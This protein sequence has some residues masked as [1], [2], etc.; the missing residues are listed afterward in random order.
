MQIQFSFSLPLLLILIIF[1]QPC[2]PKSFLDEKSGVLGFIHDAEEIV[3]MVQSDID[4][5][6][7]ERSEF[8][9]AKKR[10]NVIKVLEHFKN[11]SV[12]VDLIKLHYIKFSKK[13]PY[14][15]VIGYHQNRHHIDDMI[16]EMFEVSRRFKKMATMQIP[17]NITRVMSFFERI[18]RSEFDNPISN[19]FY[20]EL[21]DCWFPKKGFTG[22]LRQKYEMQ[23]RKLCSN[24][25]S[26]QQIVYSLY[27]DIALT[28]LKAYILLEY[29]LLIRRTVG[30]R[31]LM[32][33]TITVRFYYMNITENSLDTLT[34]TMQKADRGVW[35]CDSLSH[36]RKVTYEEVT[37]LIQ[38]YVENEVDLNNTESCS[39]ACPDYPNTTTMGYLDQKLC[40]QQ[41]KCLGPIHDCHS[42]GSNLTVCQ[43]PE[44]SNR[45]YEFIQY[46]DGS[47]VGPHKECELDFY[48][49]GSSSKIFSK[50]NYRFCL[51]DEQGPKS[52]R[53][54]NLRDIVSDLWANKVVTGV[55]FVKKH[56]IFHLQIQ[57]GQVLPRGSINES[58]VEWVPIDDYKITDPDIREGIDYHPLSH[59]ERGIDLDE[60]SSTSDE[61]SV[62]TGLRF[63]VSRGRLYLVVIFSPLD[64]ERG[65]LFQ[66]RFISTY[67]QPV[68]EARQKLDL[69]NLDIPT[70]SIYSS[71]PM[72][73]SNQYLEF[74]NTGM[75]KDAA[76]TTIPFIDIQDV[77][78]NPPVP[79]AGIGIYYKSS[80]GYGGF[81]APK[82][83]TYDIS[84]HVRSTNA[85]ISVAV[86]HL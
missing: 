41:P 14:E 31:N 35:R 12:Q 68:N 6:D 27:K 78:S 8:D 16:Y 18:D 86:D 50:C 84:Q 44:S 57:Q 82:I 75:E 20:L 34:T 71:Q 43:S 4:Q 10:E 81:V 60:I 58:T 51:C 56:R 47:R 55:R 2:Q 40:S 73:K 28:E 11:I 7:K 33:K 62:V 48:N 23:S 79:L 63:R 52:D 64:F 76:Q 24:L 3:R 45:R 54:F 83:I 53:Y 32:W 69:D 72:S 9:I 85:V 17:Q 19:E 15:S 74:V 59:Q 30:Q 21:F 39:E 80:S 36:V 22:E 5:L 13:S 29:A 77:V 65:K 66:Q 67:K 70:R 25:Q 61:T 42:V 38:G 37:R 26:P 49:R 1:N 46:G